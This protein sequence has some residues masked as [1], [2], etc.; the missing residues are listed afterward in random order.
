MAW[1]TWPNR[2]AELTEILDDRSVP[3]E[4]RFQVLAQ[5]PRVNRWLG[6]WWALRAELERIADRGALGTRLLDVG[7][8]VGDLGAQVRRWAES[9]GGLW[10][11]GVDISP[12]LLEQAASWSVVPVCASGQALPFPDRSFDVVTA[13]MLLHHFSGAALERLFSELCRVARRAVIINDLYRHRFAWLGWQ[14][15]S[16]LFT[17]DQIIRYD[18]AVSIRKGFVAE[19]LYALG[20]SVEGF[21]WE[22]RRHPGFRICLTGLRDEGGAT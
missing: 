1:W 21:H 16:L 8:G 19:D 9:R 17:N 11:V 2:P 22:V 15:W 10:V 14:L 7:C 4:V 12:R 6:G 18:G 20:R 5:L 13:S 3:D